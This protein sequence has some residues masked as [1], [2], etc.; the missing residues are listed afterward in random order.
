MYKFK[1]SSLR[2]TSEKEVDWVLDGEYGGARTEVEIANLREKVK[3]M[4][5]SE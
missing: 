2:I 4:L 5:G 1:T 3:I